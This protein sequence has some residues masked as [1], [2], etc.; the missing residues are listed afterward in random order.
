MQSYNNKWRKIITIF[1]RICIYS[2]VYQNCV[3]LQIIYKEILIILENN[4]KFKIA[5]I[6]FYNPYFKYYLLW[7]KYDKLIKL[8]F[9]E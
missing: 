5:I 7:L 4:V 2:N 3:G 1:C 9:I 8:K 6:L